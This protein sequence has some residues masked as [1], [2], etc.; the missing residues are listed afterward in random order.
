[1]LV[2][3]FGEPDGATGVERLSPHAVANN[4]R[5]TRGSVRVITSPFTEHRVPVLRAARQTPFA[6]R[7]LRCSSATAAGPLS[8]PGRAA[9]VRSVT[10]PL[11]APV[12]EPIVWPA[13]VEC[14][15]REAG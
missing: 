14:V 1:M 8:I 11:I 6:S 7:N 4:R 12:M 15:Q 5:Q 3:P 9:L 13:P 10:V 2:E